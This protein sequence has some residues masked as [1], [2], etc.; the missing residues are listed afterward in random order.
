M[1]SDESC[2][3]I[4]WLIVMVEHTCLNQRLRIT[5]ARVWFRL[6]IISIRFSVLCTL[7]R[8]SSRSS[9][10]CCLP[11]FAPFDTRRVSWIANSRWRVMQDYASAM[12]GRLMFCL[13]FVVLCHGVLDSTRLCWVEVVLNGVMLR[14]VFLYSSCAL[15]CCI[16]VS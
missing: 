10:S 5:N 3:L 7:L 2:I 11:T 15:L 13:C 16:V 6:H 14:C 8:S 9:A 12:L 4:V 1:H